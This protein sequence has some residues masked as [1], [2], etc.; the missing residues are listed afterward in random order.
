MQKTWG[1]PVPGSNA[2]SLTMILERFR[3]IVKYRNI[4]VNIREDI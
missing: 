2:A 4:S 3:V 1:K